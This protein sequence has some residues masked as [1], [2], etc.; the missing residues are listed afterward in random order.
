[1]CPNAAQQHQFG[2]IIIEKCC[3]IKNNVYICKIRRENEWQFTM[4]A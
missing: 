3:K 2:E 4:A 1:M